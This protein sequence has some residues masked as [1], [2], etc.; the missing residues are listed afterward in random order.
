MAK[1]TKTKSSVNQSVLEKYL[2]SA[3]GATV[4]FV[5]GS[6]KS[7]TEEE[8]V[9]DTHRPKPKKRLETLY[10]SDTDQKLVDELKVLFNEKKDSDRFLFT[11]IPFVKQT[12]TYSP[13]I[14]SKEQ[15]NKKAKLTIKIMQGGKEIKKLDSVS[16][17]S[18][19]I[20]KAVK[21]N[22]KKIIS[23]QKY[24]GK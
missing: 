13:I 18:L 14:D 12:K 24:N 16:S 17:G 11:T 23:V 3:G 9:V 2:S 15:K 8:V 19:C 20:K 4:Q 1:K 7:N 22:V 5:T 6:I 10:W 21:E